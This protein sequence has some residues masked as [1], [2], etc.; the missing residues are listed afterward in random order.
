MTEEEIKVAF[1][2]RIKKVFFS[3]IICVLCVFPLFISAT[4]E[5]VYFNPLL[6]TVTGVFIFS[7]GFNKYYKCPNCEKTPFSIG[8][9]KIPKVCPNCGVQLK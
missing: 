6:L 1:R 2:G 8:N 7:I 4:W 3:W 5:F 9:G